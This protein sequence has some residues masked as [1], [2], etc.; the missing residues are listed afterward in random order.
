VQIKDEVRAALE[1]VDYVYKIFGFKY[2]LEL[3]TV[4]VI[5]FFCYTCNICSSFWY[6]CDSYHEMMTQAAGMLSLIFLVKALN[7]LAMKHRWLCIHCC[8]S[9]FIMFVEYIF[10]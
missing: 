5:S 1:F 10:G 8:I 4:I 9:R 7:I 3:S 2:E 6:I